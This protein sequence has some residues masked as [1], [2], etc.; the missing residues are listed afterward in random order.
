M[1]QFSARGAID[2]VFEEF[3]A[4]RDDVD[5]SMVGLFYL[6]MGCFGRYVQRQIDTG[7][8]AELVR[9]YELLRKLMLDGDEDVQNAVGVAILEHLLLQDGKVARRWAL[10][11]MPA[12]L[13]QC[14]GALGRGI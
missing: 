13:R 12:V 2:A 8:R 5:S 14:F 11:A 4:V 1:P 10:D 7:N 6:E 9:S 3:P